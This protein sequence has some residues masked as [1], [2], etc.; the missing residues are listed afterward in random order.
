MFDRN[1]WILLIRSNQYRYCKDKTWSYVESKYWIK[2]EI[3]CQ[4][5]KID[6]KINCI[7]WD[8]FCS[9]LLA[10]INIFKNITKTSILYIKIMSFLISVFSEKKYS[11]FKNPFNF[12]I[13]CYYYMITKQ[14]LWKYIIKFYIQLYKK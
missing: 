12:K 14:S 6:F 3:F 1:D 7:W 9:I 11:T 13:Y 10:S 8:S 4:F 5:N 2:I